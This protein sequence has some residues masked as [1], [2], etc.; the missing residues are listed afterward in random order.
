MMN[1]KR[2]KVISST[3][4]STTNLVALLLLLFAASVSTSNAQSTNASIT[5]TVTDRTGDPLTGATIMLRNEETGFTTGTVTNLSGIY[6]IQQIPLGRRYT[7]TIS[8]TGFA[9]Q[10]ITNQAFNQGDQLRMDFT[11]IESTEMLQEV[12]VTADAM[13][14]V[15]DRMGSKTSISRTNMETLP[16]NGRNFAT[17]IDLS[18]VARG[19]NLLGQLFS[20]TNYT[21]DGMT[22]RSP[23]SSGTTNRGPFSISMEAI[24]EFEIVTNSYDVTNGRS[25]GGTVSAVTRSGTNQ[26]EGS[27]FIYNR[28]D[29]LSSQFDTRGVRRSNEFSTN[30]FG[31]TLA[32]PLVRDKAHFFV[33]Y[34][35]QRSANPL[36]IADISSTDDE[37]INGISRE[38]L[39]RF[40]Q[41]ARAQYGVSNTPQTGSFDRVRDTHTFFARVDWQLDR[42]N[43]LTIRNNFTRDMNNQ[44]VNDNSRH[45]LYEV[46][47]THLSMANSFLASLRTVISPVLTNEVKVQYLYT[48]DDGRPND[49]L[50]SAN[51]PRAIVENVSSVINGQTYNTTLQIG[52]QRYL[53]ETFESNL[54]QVVNNLYY[55]RQ[56]VNYTFG[57]DLML[58]NLSSL[59]TSEF[60][61][62]FFFTGLTN[63]ENMTPY[64]YAREV[65]LQ[66]PEVVQNIFGGGIYAQA[67]FNM[68]RD[69]EMTVGVRGDYTNYFNSPEF[70]PIVAE[71]L[72]KR[73][74]VSA[75]GFQLQPRFQA[76]WNIMGRNTDIIKVG[77]GMFGSA[78]NNYSDVNNLQFDGNKIYAIDVRGN[79]VPTP[80]FPAYRADPATAPGP[81]LIANPDVNPV[82]TINMNSKDIKVPTVYKGNISYNRFFGERV[83]LG[84]NFIAS[85]ARNNYMYIDANM[86]D[87]PY[88]RLSNEA[89]RGVFV[90]ASTINPANGSA[91]WTQGRKTDR[92][93]RV[94]ELVSEGKNDTYTVV[95]D[96]SYLY[97]RDGSITASYTWNDSR[98]NTSYNGNVA[99][100]A[101]LSQMVVDD[102]RDLSTMSY[103]NVQF[104]DK[105]VVYGTL[106]T[107]AG[108]KV[109]VRYSG[110]GGTRYSLRV[111]GNVNGDFVASN[112]LAFVFDPND[113]NTAPAVAQAMQAVLNNG[114]SLARE[115]VAKYVGRI[116][117]RNGCENGYFG[118]WDLRVSRKFM[119]PGSRTGM[120]LA[121]D[122]FNVANL[123]DKK[124]GVTKTLGDQNLLNIRGFNP[125]TQQYI[126]AVNPNVGVVSPGGTPW[127]F[128]VSAR[129]MF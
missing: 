96:G 44:G 117:E 30:Q 27:A 10:T 84:A 104:R 74:D 59:A 7:I 6:N 63:F 103:S 29:Q 107:M 99:N 34:D 56:G 46:Y 61:G 108:F 85:F 64:R 45:N 33:T 91:D 5:G 72:G 120:E 94:L 38:T 119:L 8:F 24:R 57:A 87:Q 70:N 90:P 19:N 121:L 81:E 36:L 15:V 25:G 39:D 83:R 16:V 129:V 9:T 11:L 89:N 92:I 101:T 18:P 48:L 55:T 126:Y 75:A 73:T 51:I 12:T 77:G 26:F 78:L 127:Q 23:L 53:P 2:R 95:V 40:L 82:V 116:A 21:I 86:V 98:D 112:D 54:F 42:N 32:G 110:I 109:G 67:Q 71:D 35:G 102:P 76:I 128:Q 123:F 41:I 105:V 14:L 13:S 111:G 58:N 17:L 79:L 1:N 49:Q 97:Y 31:F 43:L 118:T 66:D 69:L 47:G 50:P 93:G 100:S 22:N 28:S 4:Q 52:G 60:N 106:P 80:N 62:R 114:D 122:M 68:T 115:C 113:P 20:S 3:F 125:E 88:F 37:I 124:S 65:A